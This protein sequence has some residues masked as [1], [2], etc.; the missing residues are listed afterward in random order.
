MASATV[1]FQPSAPET[2]LENPVPIRK[3][4]LT[5]EFVSADVASRLSN[6]RAIPDAFPGLIGSSEA[7]K[8]VK[9]Q[10]R[11]V[12][13]TDSTVL[14]EGETGT[15]LVARNRQFWIGQRRGIAARPTFPSK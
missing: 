4:E 7:I 10:V 13:V 11:T 2:W 6:V 12:A 8:R 9:Q 1:S 15:A 5:D 3:P 14:L